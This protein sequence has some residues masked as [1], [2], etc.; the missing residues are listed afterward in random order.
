MAGFKYFYTILLLLAQ[1]C[2]I[3][4]HFG[5]FGDIMK[6]FPYPVNTFVYLFILLIYRLLI[7]FLKKPD[8]VNAV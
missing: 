4:L 2:K 1:I 3:T 7:K 5:I 6:I 8:T